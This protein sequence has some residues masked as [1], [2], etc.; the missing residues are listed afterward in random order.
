MTLAFTASILLSRHSNSYSTLTTTFVHNLVVLLKTGAGGRVSPSSNAHLVG[1]ALS[2]VLLSNN[3]DEL[4][5]SE[6]SDS[7][8]AAE[9]KSA[10]SVQ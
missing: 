1:S 7:L 5:V 8:A 2:C 4:L 9:T 10:I 3:E 6:F